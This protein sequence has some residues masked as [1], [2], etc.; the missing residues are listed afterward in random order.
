MRLRQLHQ[1]YKSQDSEMFGARYKQEH[2]HKGSSILWVKFEYLYEFYQL[3]TLDAHILA[4]W[5]L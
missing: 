2:F 4:L 1:W 5:C 3:S